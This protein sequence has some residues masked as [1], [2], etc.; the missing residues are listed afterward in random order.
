MNEPRGNVDP[1]EI[2]KFE[3]LAHRWWDADGEFRPLHEINPLR[4]GFIE[5]HAAGLVGK[6]VLD[7]GCGGGILSESM[8]ARGAQVTGIDM[9][10]APLSVARLH[11]LE[12]GVEIEYRQV[13][14]EAL[15]AERPGSYDVVTCMEMLEHVPDP[16]SVV[17]ACA[18]LVKPDGHVFFSTLN[19][20]PKSFLFAIVGAEYLLKLLPRGT[21]EYQRFIRPSELDRAI[22]HAGLNLVDIAGMHFNPLTH[23]YSL[24]T[25]VSVNYLVHAVVQ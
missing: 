13:T 3:E 17:R 14:V 9:G 24:S 23:A 5:Q 22:R 10:E 4:L 12:T 8:A 21:H 7:V 6:T 18:A 11:G 15:A 25:D 1:R 19:R 20:N 2:G 16:E